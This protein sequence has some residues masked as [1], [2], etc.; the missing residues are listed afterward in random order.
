[1]GRIYRAIVPG[2]PHH[3]RNGGYRLFIGPGRCQKYLRLVS[4]QFQR[5]EI[6]VL[7]W[8]L[9]PNHVH[10]VLV[11]TRADSLSRVLG[12]AHRRYARFVNDQLGLKRHAV[13]AGRF[14]ACALDGDHLLAAARM[15][16][17]DPVR[18][19]LVKQPE[20]WQW[21]SAQFHLGLG[22]RDWLV[23]RRELPARVAD[24][25]EW[26]ER[27][28]PALERRVRECTASGRPAGSRRFI[29]RAAMHI[30]KKLKKRRPGPKPHAWT[31]EEKLWL[32]WALWN[33]EH[34]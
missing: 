27:A 18:A 16:E 34:G 5:H 13:F 29:L 10:L 21:S 2:Y 4:E 9:M 7:A 14:G 22:E 26:L 30:R 32:K 8:C 1:M 23:R 11:P 25:R 12:T 17:M 15:A 33:Q 20:D 31:Y 28:E 3:V 24:W 19:K 6:S